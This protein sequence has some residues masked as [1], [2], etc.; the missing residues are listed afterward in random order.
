MHKF[1]PE[2][3]HEFMHEL[4]LQYPELTHAWVLMNSLNH[5]SFRVITHDLKQCRCHEAKYLQSTP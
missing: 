1:S 2:L 3:V 5:N 4:K